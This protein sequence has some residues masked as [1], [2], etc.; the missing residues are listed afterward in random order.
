MISRSVRVI[1]DT[2]VWISFLIGKRLSKI[3][4]YI[5]DGRITI[6]TCEQLITEIR[7]VTGREKMKKYFQKDDVEELLELLNIIAEKVEIKPTHFINR[8]PKD[9]FLLDLIYFS[10]ADYLITGDK[11]LQE[12]NPF[13][14]AQILTPS[15]FEHQIF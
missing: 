8:D 3:K 1:F 5:L 7:L 2:N 11:D 14:T 13:R 9:N 10:N 15:E 4:Q 6:I 12:H